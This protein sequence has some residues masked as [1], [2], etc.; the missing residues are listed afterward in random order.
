MPQHP[1]LPTRAEINVYDSLDERCAVEHFLGKDL[2]Q[3]EE[4]FR[5]NFL[6]YREDLMWMGPKAFCFYVKAAI[7]YLK[8][9]E[10]FDDWDAISCFHTVVDFQLEYC[11]ADIVPAFDVLRDAVETVLKNLA[12]QPTFPMRYGDVAAKYR[13]L[14]SRLQTAP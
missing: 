4:L 2:D 14:L 11:R 9:P 8:D 5:E 13:R 10:G 12:D 3:A 1:A 6:K 7:R